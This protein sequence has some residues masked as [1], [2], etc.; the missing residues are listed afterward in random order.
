MPERYYETPGSSAFL[1]YSFL[2]HEARTMR[3]QQRTLKTEA[4]EADAIVAERLRRAAK[5]L[6]R[7]G[8]FA[9]IENRKA[10]WANMFLAAPEALS[11][12]LPRVERNAREGTCSTQETVD[13]FLRKNPHLDPN[14]RDQKRGVPLQRALDR[15]A[16]A[17][18]NESH[19]YAFEGEARDYLARNG[20]ARRDVATGAE[21]V[22]V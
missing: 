7:P 21:P 22:E 20:F 12:F 1:P 6:A 19:P 11:R 2:V 17:T 8:T 18:C 13:R 4:R 9:R 5:Y 10:L 15:I 16:L 14:A 3:E